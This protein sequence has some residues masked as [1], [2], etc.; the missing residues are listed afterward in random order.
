MGRRLLQLTLTCCILMLLSKNDA[1]ILF[2]TEVT[3]PQADHV[4]ASREY[5]VESGVVTFF[6]PEVQRRVT[7]A[8]MTWIKDINEAGEALSTYENVQLI[9]SFFSF[10]DWSTYFPLALEEYTYY[11]ML[12]AIAQYPA[13]CNEY[14]TGSGQANLHSKEFACKRELATLFA[15][16]IHETRDR[17]SNA[18]DPYKTGLSYDEEP[19]C[20]GGGEHGVSD[21]CHYHDDF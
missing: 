19:G 18:P 1:K 10:N 17:D 5:S 14:D 20:E 7:S 6:D 9:K 8:Q 13:F 11:R 21:Y 12:K 2:D 15:H 4:A 3:F 16:I